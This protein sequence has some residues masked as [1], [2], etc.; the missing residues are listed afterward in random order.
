[1]GERLKE[2]VDCVALF[3]CARLPLI[4]LILEKV[5]SYPVDD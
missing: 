1:M 3:L 5:A 2:V 4:P